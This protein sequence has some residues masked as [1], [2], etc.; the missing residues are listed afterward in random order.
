MDPDTR[1]SESE[2]QK[3]LA[4]AAQQQDRADAPAE[5]SHTGL[6]LMRLQEVAADVGIAPTH[7][8]AAAREVLLHRQHAGAGTQLGLPRELRAMRTVPGKA[9][10]AQ[11]ERMVSE[12][13][14]IFKKNGIPSQFG[15][16]REWIST[17]ESGESMPVVVRLEPAGAETRIS[18]HQSI[19]TLSS[20][21]WGLGGGFAGVGVLFGVMQQIGMVEP[22]ALVFAL[23]M[24][25]VG[26]VVSGGSWVA[27]RLWAE[28]QQR[29]L[30]RAADRAELI[31]RS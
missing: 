18:V 24:L 21:T 15:D 13:R 3:I 20:L 8:E 25:V 11:W 17:N 23:I 26:I 1:F 2:V 7:V 6:S 27:S 14:G 12:F 31:L 29:A 19:G 30:D 4:R 28:Q 5:E 16:V 10:D 22:D 9:S